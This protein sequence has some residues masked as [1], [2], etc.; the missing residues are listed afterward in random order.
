MNFIVIIEICFL[1]NSLMDS[2]TYRGK[3]CLSWGLAVLPL[4]FAALLSSK[5][6]PD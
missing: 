1:K 4:C 6:G 5:V 2:W 3:N